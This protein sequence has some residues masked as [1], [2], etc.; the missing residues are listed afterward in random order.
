MSQ[1]PARQF[2]TAGNM[3]PPMPATTTE[4]VTLTIDGQHHHRAQGHQR[5]RPRARRREARHQRVSATTRA[6]RSRRAAGSAWSPSRRT[7]KLQPSPTIATDG[8]VVHTTD[9]Q[10]TLARKQMLE[11]TW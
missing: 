11:F 9:A 2:D 6:C 10:S 7:R 1:P 8:M 4:T 3:P 5:S